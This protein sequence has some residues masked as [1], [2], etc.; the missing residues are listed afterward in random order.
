MKFNLVGVRCIKPL[1]V[2]S[3]VLMASTA[4]I[5]PS[6][7]NSALPPT[8]VGK[9][10]DTFIQRTSTRFGESLTEAPVE[11]SGTS[12]K[13]TNGIY[14][15]SYEDIGQLRTA[16]PGDKVKLCLLRIPENCPPGDN[17]GRVYSLLNYRTSG[18]VEMPDSQHMCGGA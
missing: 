12:V 8:Q 6:P 9:C 17:R 4:V 10:A 2:K 5:V 1:V 7:A 13:L 11:G 3:L 14:L 18:Y 15:V 16:R